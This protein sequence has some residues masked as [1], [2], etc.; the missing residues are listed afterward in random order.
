MKY[1]LTILLI[2]FWLFA[3]CQDTAKWTTGNEASISNYNVQKS[4]DT[5]SWTTIAT[6][7]KGK[8]SYWYILPRE[9]NYYRVQASGLESFVTR[10]ILL[11]VA[12]NRASIT[13]AVKTSTTLSFTITGE[14][15]VNYYLIQK[16]IN[17]FKTYSTTTKLYASGKG[18]Y[19]YRYTKTIYQ[20]SYRVTAVF[21]D[22]KTGLPVTFK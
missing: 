6:L 19:S 14:N 22:G 18:K 2:L 17:G 1:I 10:P 20:Y 3:V 7:S 8:K 21:S 15:N 11:T 5:A 13:N 9:T 12:A 16:S 4:K